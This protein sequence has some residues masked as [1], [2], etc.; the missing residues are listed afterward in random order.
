MANERPRSE[1]LLK[2]DSFA[3]KS[4]KYPLPK[5]STAFKAIFKAVQGAREIHP[6]KVHG[7]GMKA[8]YTDNTKLIC[9]T[10]DRLGIQYIM[11]NVN[12]EAGSAGRVILIR[13]AFQD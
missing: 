10:L 13:T 1:T 4:E 9:K 11:E 6:V 2:L 8:R 12:P 3:K 5:Q 7:E